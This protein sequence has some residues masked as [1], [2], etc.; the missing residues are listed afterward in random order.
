VTGEL[1]VLLLHVETAKRGQDYGILFIFSL[2]CEYINLDYVRVPVV[3]RA[4]QAEYG[5]HILVVAPQEY[6]NVYSTRRVLVVGTV[7]SV[8]LSPFS[9]ISRVRGFFFFISHII[10]LTPQQ[11]STE[12]R[13]SAGAEALAVAS[14]A[15][16]LVGAVMRPTALY[17]PPHPQ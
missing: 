2:F 10:Q 15:S 5:I 9:L 12:P 6:V 13:N 8:P 1:G 14:V 16:R 11:Q 4:N 7:L 17:S 3:Y